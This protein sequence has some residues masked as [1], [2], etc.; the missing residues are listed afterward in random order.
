[1]RGGEFSTVRVDVYA[2]GGPHKGKR[3]SCCHRESF[4]DSH[5]GSLNSCRVVS[6][7]VVGIE[8]SQFNKRIC[9]FVRVCSFYSKLG[10]VMHRVCDT[11]IRNL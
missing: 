2:Q 8:N 3:R 6:C 5:F 1:M 7:R 4:G 9:A 10:T 11:N